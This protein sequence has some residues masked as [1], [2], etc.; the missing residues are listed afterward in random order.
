IGSVKNKAT[1]TLGVIICVGRCRP[2]TL[3]NTKQGCI[4][5][6]NCSEHSI[7]VELSC[8]LSEFACKVIGET[9]APP[10]IADHRITLRQPFPEMPE[11][12]PLPLHFEMRE[13]AQ[14]SNKHRTRA[15]CG[16]CNT[17][18]IRGL[19]KSNVLLSI[20]RVARQREDFRSNPLNVGR[21]Y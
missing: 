12:G 17:H 4:F 1:N 20:C 6:P 8:L 13:K 2:S 7:E 15:D 19:A 9:D 21:T 14:H 5:S 16:I 3:R 11:I 10:V 18:P